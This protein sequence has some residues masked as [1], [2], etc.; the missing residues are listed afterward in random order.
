LDFG[1]FQAKVDCIQSANLTG[2]I[3]ILVRCLVVH[4]IGNAGLCK[5]AGYVAHLIFAFLSHGG[6]LISEAISDSRQSK[7]Y[8]KGWGHVFPSQNSKDVYIVPGVPVMFSQVTIY[9]S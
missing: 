4:V 1:P 7:L 5:N 2:I 6:E 9:D 3:A 8:S